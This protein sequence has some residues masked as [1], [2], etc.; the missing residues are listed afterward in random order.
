MATAPGRLRHCLK[1][2]NVVVMPTENMRSPSLAVSYCIYTHNVCIYVLYY[3]YDDIISYI[4]H[5]QYVQVRILR[6]MPL[7]YK[8][9]PSSKEV[10]YLD[11]T[12]VKLAS[13]GKRL[14]IVKPS[15]APRRL[16]VS[17]MLAESAPLPLQGLAILRRGCKT[18]GIHRLLMVHEGYFNSIISIYGYARYILNNLNHT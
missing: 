2:S 4:K 17:K 11:F 12:H 9:M 6:P 3:I 13:R 8:V 5:R 15:K 7:R 1:S 10:K 18:C 16:M 14:K